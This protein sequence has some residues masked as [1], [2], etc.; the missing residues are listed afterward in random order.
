M[1][2]STD[3]AEFLRRVRG[4]DADAATEL[5]HRYE[6]VI[7]REARMRLSDPRLGRLLD[8]GDVCQSVLA[9]FFVRA[10]AGQYDLEAPAQLVALLAVMTRNKVAF[11]ARKQNAQRRDARRL[12]AGDVNDMGVADPG[13]SPS[14]IAA[15]REL[16]ALVHDRL[17][18]DERLVAD[19]RAA[20]AGWAEV[21][22]EL[23][24][25]ADGRRM[26]LTRAL[27]RVSRELG[28]DEGDYA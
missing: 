1:P 3:F 15:G 6:A 16:L 10:A 7:R 11:A 9:S 13:A 25:T 4:G 26:Q 21:A 22:A 20:G 8:S 14:R 28:I 27:D 18:D 12:E 5:F 19:R 17:S 24:G 2:D 23:G